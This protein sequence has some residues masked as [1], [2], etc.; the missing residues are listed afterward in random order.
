MKTAK[1]F[2]GQKGSGTIRKANW[3]AEKKYNDEVA[4]YKADYILE[5][6]RDNQV[7]PLDFARCKLLVIMGCAKTFPY[8]FFV[9]SIQKGFHLESDEKGKMQDKVLDIIFI[10]NERPINLPPQYCEH[11]EVRRFSKSWQ[12]KK[13]RYKYLNTKV[14]LYKPSKTT[15]NVSTSI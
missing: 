8:Y 7:F 5:C 12:S 13:G 3:L 6:Y 9:Q 10:S 11:F 2:Y 1:I 4:F 15:A 14:H